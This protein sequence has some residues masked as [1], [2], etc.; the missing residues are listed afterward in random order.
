MR[1]IVRIL[2]LVGLVAVVVAAIRRLLARDVPSPTP[3]TPWQPVAPTPATPAPTTPT[4]AP[5]T[6]EAETVAPE[7]PE[8][9]PAADVG[10]T[11]DAPA[12]GEPASVEPGPDGSCPEGYPVKANLSSGIF[13]VPGGLS[14]ERTR[15]DRC[16]RDQAAAE[17]DGLRQSKR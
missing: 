9:E 14:Y 8:P 5:G 6:G 16:Y 12:S 1:R 15:P 13:H 10:D 4:P 2:I 17:D 11:G 7:E 3:T